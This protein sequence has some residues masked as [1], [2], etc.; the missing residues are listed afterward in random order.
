[1]RTRSVTAFGCACLLIAVLGASRYTI[2][3]TAPTVSGTQV[4]QSVHEKPAQQAEETDR[5]A[6]SE[7]T[8]KAERQPTKDEIVIALLLLLASLR[9]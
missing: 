1:M 8:P 5:P 2:V 6:H 9:H 4:T 3:D 7:R